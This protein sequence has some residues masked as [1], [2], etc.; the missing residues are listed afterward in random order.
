MSSLSMAEVLSQFGNAYADQYPYRPEQQQVVT[1]IRQCRT[2][3][4]GY[5]QIYCNECKKETIQYHSCRNR[6]CPQCQQKASN[7]WKDKC[8]N[9]LLPVP[10]FH[11]VFTLPHALNG[12]VRLHPKVLYRLLFQSVW[13]TLNTFGQEFM[14]S[15]VNCTQAL[16]GSCLFYLIHR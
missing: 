9:N 2:P 7:D 3:A 4:L 6:H 14:L 5:T 12:W 10:Y 16:I 1:C 13:Q 11:L 8:L 15:F